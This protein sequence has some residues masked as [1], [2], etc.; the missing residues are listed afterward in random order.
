[1]RVIANKRPR[2]RTRFTVIASS[3]IGTGSTRDYETGTE[4]EQTFLC[5]SVQQ[6]RSFVLSHCREFLFRRDNRAGRSLKRDR[7]VTGWFSEKITRYFDLS[8]PRVVL[9]RRQSRHRISLSRCPRFWVAPAPGCH[10]VGSRC[11]KGYESSAAAV[12]TDE[13]IVQNDSYISL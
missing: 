12:E 2:G 3:S 8:L 11:S 9:P 13:A 6:F 1:M 4:D 10:F 7:R 5:D